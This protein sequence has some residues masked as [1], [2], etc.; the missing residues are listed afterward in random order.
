MNGHSS[1]PIECTLYPKMQF[2]HSHV[3]NGVT[4]VKLWILSNGHIVTMISMYQKNW[5]HSCTIIALK[6][7]YIRS[8]IKKFVANKEN[9]MLYGD[10]ISW[11][12]WYQMLL[13]CVELNIIKICRSNMT[14]FMLQMVCVDYEFIVNWAC[15]K[16]YHYFIILHWY[17][18]DE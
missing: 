6:K 8:K 4:K 1:M 16:I 3:V 10:T 12:L 17:E 5:Y 11:S 13:L 14:I 18:N 15:Y 2:Y 9:I 7:K